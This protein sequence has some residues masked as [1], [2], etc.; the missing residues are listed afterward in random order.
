[1]IVRGVKSCTINVEQ[2]GVAT[3]RD[4][5]IND[6]PLCSEIELAWCPVERENSRIV[7]LSTEQGF[8]P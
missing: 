8:D 5:V 2:C 4:Y 6:I 1:M 3:P 7:V